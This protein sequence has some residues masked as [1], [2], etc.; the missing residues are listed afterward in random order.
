VRE[1]LL[2]NPRPAPS[3]LV[4]A[5]AGASVL[6][7]GLPIFVLA[8]WRVKAW[9]LAAVLWL[10]SQMLGLLLARLRVGM[11]SLASSGVLAIGMMS[12]AIVVMIVLIAIAV[13]DSSVGLPAAALYAVAYTC[14]LGFSLVSYFGSPAR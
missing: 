3:R 6:L 13:S 11:D 10:G 7:L 8:D 1:G 9:G 12:R 14:E 4:P 2:R 5:L